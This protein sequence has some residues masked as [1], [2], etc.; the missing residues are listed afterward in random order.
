MLGLRRDR[1]D[2]LAAPRKG[3]RVKIAAVFALVAVPLAFLLGAYAYY[4]SVGDA[5]AFRRAVQTAEVYPC[6]VKSRDRR[7]RGR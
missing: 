2:R 4:E 5:M 7:E 6:G 3:G 1:P